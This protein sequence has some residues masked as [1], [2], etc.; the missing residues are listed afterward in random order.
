ME[1][2]EK[3]TDTLMDHAI[4]IAYY[5]RGAIQFEEIFERT[6]YERMK[7]VQFIK[8]HLDAESEKVK[9]SKGKLHAI[10]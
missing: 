7:I 8:K 10:Y 4:N 2:L 5:M 6:Y 9:K 3:G 1:S